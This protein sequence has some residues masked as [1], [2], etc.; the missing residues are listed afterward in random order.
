MELWKPGNDYRV[1]ETNGWVMGG[2]RNIFI[3]YAFSVFYPVVIPRQ[4]V[5][6]K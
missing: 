6:I 1:F 3:N 2:R 4:N 5:S